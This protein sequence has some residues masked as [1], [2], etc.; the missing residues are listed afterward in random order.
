MD[1]K[2]KVVI[3]TGASSGI[4]AAA[5]LEFGREG[6]KVVLAARRTDKLQELVNEIR[7][8]QN[9]AEAFVLQTD[10][11][12]LDD[13]QRLV[14]QTVERFGRVDVLVNN[15][16]FGRLKWLETLDPLE[17][18]QA[19]FDVNVLGVI[20]TTRQVLPIMIK[21]RS[22]SIINIC[23]IAGLVGTPTYTIYS[24]TKHAVHG[25][26]EALRREV[27]PWGIDVSL[28]YPGGVRGTEFPDHAGIQRKT[29]ASTPKFMVLTAE[30]VGK[31]VVNLV[32]RPRRMWVLPWMWRFTI[33]LNRFLP[34]L[35]DRTTIKNFTIPERADELNKK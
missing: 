5:A 8:M 25:F 24:A 11:S 1:I 34:G 10:I 26:S 12:K 6:A 28:I 32:H 22:G 19:Q 7:A 29:N 33:F 2:G 21:Q 35:V 9:G 4:G 31:A 23:S 18:I 27:K 17:D 13:I 16:G 14:A 3:I 30:Q 15:A 20:Q